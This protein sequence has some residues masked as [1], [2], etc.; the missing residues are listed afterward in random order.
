MPQQS[1]RRLPLAVVVGIVLTLG[2]CNERP[3][4]AAS[5]SLQAGPTPPILPIDD[6]LAAAGTLSATDVTS[7]NLAARAAG[8]RARARAL[9]GPVQD[10]AT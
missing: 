8:L 7:A 1:S 2:A 5:R 4:L 6:V 3:E 9:Q 10:P